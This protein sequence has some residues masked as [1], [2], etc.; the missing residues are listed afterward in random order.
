LKQPIEIKQII[1]I[2]A[3]ALRAREAR[4]SRYGRLI[5]RIRPK[6][7]SAEYE[8]ALCIEGW[9]ILFNEPIALQS[10]EI[11]VFERGCFDAHLATRGT[12]FRL[13]HDPSQVVGSTSSG[14]ELYAADT[15]LAYRMPLTNKLYASTIK[16]KVESN[17]QSAI[18]V[19]ITRSTERSE[20]FGKH[21]VVFIEQAELTEFSLVAEGCCEQA[22]ACLIDANDAPSFKD[23]IN[24]PSFKLESVAHNMRT[25]FRKKMRKLEALTERITALQVTPPLKPMTANQ[26]NKLTTENYDQMRT[27]RRAKLLGA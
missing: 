15:G 6:S 22:F 1:E 24:S 8:Q 21:K 3:S 14:L 2:D 18:S 19:G 23:S 9:A 12:D 27:A 13:A 20:T 7:A 5:N 10:G 11:V 16:R 4:Q 26:S 17:S 25:Q